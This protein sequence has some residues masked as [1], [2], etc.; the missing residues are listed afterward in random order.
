MSMKPPLSPEKVEAFRNAQRLYR[1][2]YSA[3]QAAPA[4]EADTSLD[5]WKEAWRALDAAEARLY[6]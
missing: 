2:A 1:Q 4:S 5:A 3:R 6:T